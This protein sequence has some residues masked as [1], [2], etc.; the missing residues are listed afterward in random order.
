[1]TIIS[2]PPLEYADPETGLL[3]V[4]GDLEIE[5]LLLA[6]EQGIFPWP[7]DSKHLTWF[8]PKQRAVLFLDDFH[9]SKS[10]KR[11]ANN[12]KLKFTENTAFN[13]VIEHCSAKSVRKKEKGTWITKDLKEAYIRLFEAGYCY[14]VEAY[15]DSNLV[16]GFYGVKIKNFI[17]AESMF[18]LKNNASKLALLYFIQELRKRKYTWIDF[19]ALNPF[20]EQLGACNIDRNEFMRLLKLSL[21]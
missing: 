14:S 3:A 19:Q 8:A 2:F 6:Y 4:G 1:M 17:S 7:I 16:A 18:H 13:T 20:T 9:C 12:S 10:L 11:Q 21:Q 15:E 5:S